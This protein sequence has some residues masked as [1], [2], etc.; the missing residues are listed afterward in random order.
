MNVE[1]LQAEAKKLGYK[2]TNW[3]IDD[4]FRSKM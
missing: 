4:E 2:L 1:E 3:R